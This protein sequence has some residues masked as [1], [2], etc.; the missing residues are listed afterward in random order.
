MPAE[1]SQ[2]LK[3]DHELLSLIKMLIKQTLPQYNR[4]LLILGEVGDF[5]TP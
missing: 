2:D 3:G 1:V 4:M 5:N